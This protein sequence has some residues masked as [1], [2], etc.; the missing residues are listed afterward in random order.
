MKSLLII[1][2]FSIWNDVI[3]NDL[4]PWEL[5]TSRTFAIVNLLL[6][7][8]GSNERIYSLYGGNDLFALF[9]TEN[10][11][12]IINKSKFIKETEKPVRHEE[13]FAT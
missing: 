2:K 13:S 9:L 8:A 4:N 10:M 7:E 12:D 1:K 11:Y 5:A 6:R 3:D